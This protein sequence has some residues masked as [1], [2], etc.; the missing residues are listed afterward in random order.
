MDGIR[1]AERNKEYGSYPDIWCM[2]NLPRHT[3]RS[4]R[5]RFVGVATIC[6][7]LL[8]IERRR[9]KKNNFLTIFY[10]VQ[11]LKKEFQ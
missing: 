10:A 7:W 2:Q 5:D 11:R 4:T 9:K 3:P 6:G 1:T 8:K